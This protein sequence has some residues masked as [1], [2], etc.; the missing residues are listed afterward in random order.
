MAVA[1]AAGP[2]HAATIS[3]SDSIFG[4]FDASN[5][6][7]TLALGAGTISDV[8]IFIDFAKCDDPAMQPGQST[9]SS[10]GE[11]FS[12]E[13][14]FYLISPSGTRVDLVYT[15]NSTPEGVAQGSNTPDGTYNLNVNVGGRIQV[16]FDDQAGSAVGPVMLTGTFRPVESLSAFNGENAL[17][18]WILGMG[19]SI[20]ADPLSY[21]SSRLDVT[22]GAAVPEPITMTL[23]GAGLAVGF[24]RRRFGAR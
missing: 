9:C 17:G 18:N 22:V 7:R 15:Y 2:A 21:F 4:S 23:V 13:T 24:A 16:T 5:S 14:F 1:L 10:P 19:D 20:G 8:N 11:E 12:G 6:T 3:A